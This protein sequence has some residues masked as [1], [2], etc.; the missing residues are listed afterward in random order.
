[1]AERTVMLALDRVE[2]VG[3][4]NEAR[5]D[6]TEK[7]MA[8]LDRRIEKI[9]DKV[10]SLRGDVKVATAFLSVIIPAL[11]YLVDKF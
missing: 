2:S 7:N 3:I 5:I 11:G 10:D 8:Q 9:E 6:N 1:M 4:R